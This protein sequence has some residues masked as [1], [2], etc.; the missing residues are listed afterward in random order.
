MKKIATLLG[1]FFLFSAF[2]QEQCYTEFRNLEYALK[3]PTS[4]RVLDLSNQDISELDYRIGKLV[5]LE[6]LDISHNG[7]LEFPWE[8]RYLK[9]LKKLNV[10][11][12]R[13]K[14]R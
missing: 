5:N 3:N 14:M 12:L 1:L 7:L 13:I 8:I 9:N 11:I 2:G 6:E 10:F 4:V